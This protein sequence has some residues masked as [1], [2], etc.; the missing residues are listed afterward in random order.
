MAK[1]VAWRCQCWSATEGCRAEQG[2]K[3]TSQRGLAEHPVP[4]APRCP[5][6]AA[7]FGQDSVRSG[8]CLPFANRQGPDAVGRA[9]NN[10]AWR[11]L[12]RRRPTRRSRLNE[13]SWWQRRRC[14]WNGV[15]ICF[16]ILMRRNFKD[17]DQQRAGPFFRQR[18]RS[19]AGRRRAS[20][21]GEMQQ[22]LVVLATQSACCHSGAK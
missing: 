18:A 20:R 9:I 10:M 13:A 12:P 4:I 5:Q 7:Y 14:Y 17:R 21:L 3:P 2:L 8:S 15:S 19:L 1:Y 6:R 11:P 16:P 22:G